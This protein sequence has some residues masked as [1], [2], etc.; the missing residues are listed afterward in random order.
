MLAIVSVVLPACV[1]GQKY[2][3]MEQRAQTAEEVNILLAQEVVLAEEELAQ[4]QLEQEEIYEEL[5]A[6]VI[7]GSIR[8]EM[9]ESGLQLTLEGDVLFSTGSSAISEDGKKLLADLSNELQDF[10]YQIIVLGHTDNQPIMTARYP[11]NWNLAADRAANV[12]NILQ[13]EGL[14]GKQLA[15]V[16]L[17]DSTPVADNE[18]AEGRAQNR[19]IEIRVR[20]VTAE[21]VGR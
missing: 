10:P 12:V 14:P 15:A 4:M 2:Y 6:L 16:S 21:D 13:A 8:M 11:S 3:D 20:P 17:G 9:L 18:S 19:R 7:A 5:E 1:S